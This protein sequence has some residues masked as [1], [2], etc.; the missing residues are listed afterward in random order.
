MLR[1]IGV[2]LVNGEELASLSNVDAVEIRRD[3]NRPAHTTVRTRAAPRRT[4][5]V[6]Q[7]CG[8]L[9][10]AAMAGAFDEVDRRVHV[11]LPDRLYAKRRQGR[12]G[13]AAACS[14]GPSVWCTG[15][16]TRR[17]RRLYRQPTPRADERF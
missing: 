3:R 5:P 15:R 11:K 14:R 13:D 4:K 7:L 12:R 16:Q 2:E 9:H 10:P 6:S 1:S 17:P 8:E